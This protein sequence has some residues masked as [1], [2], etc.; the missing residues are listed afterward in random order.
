MFIF[1]YFLQVM[2]SWKMSSSAVLSTSTQKR[3]TITQV[4]FSATNLITD[5]TLS[6]GNR[7]HNPTGI[8]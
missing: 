4:S 5:S 6:C 1:E 7:S 8:F 2:M 3:M